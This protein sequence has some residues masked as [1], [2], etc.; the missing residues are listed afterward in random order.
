MYYAM[1]Y[2]MASSFK[3]KKKNLV[4]VNVVVSP[5]YHSVTLLSCQQNMVEIYI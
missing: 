2:A 4:K 5:T 3:K 1:S